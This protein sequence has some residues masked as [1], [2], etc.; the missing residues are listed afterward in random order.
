MKKRAKD[1]YIQFK[2]KKQQQQKSPNQ[3]PINIGKM[4]DIIGIEK[5]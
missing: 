3:K 2:I 5:M 4:L 1:M